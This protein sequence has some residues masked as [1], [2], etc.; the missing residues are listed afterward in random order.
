MSPVDHPD[1]YRGVT[2]EAI[3]VIEAFDLNFNLG[4]SVKYI[5]RCNR[6]GKKKE[7]LKKAIWYLQREINRNGADNERP[8]PSNRKESGRIPWHD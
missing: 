3:E 4:N 2:M 5:L 8:S 6:K 7:D 1:H